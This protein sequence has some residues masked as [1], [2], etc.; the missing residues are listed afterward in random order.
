[1]H[2]VQFFFP[3]LRAIKSRLEGKRVLDLR[4]HI[5]E[6]GIV[7]EAVRRCVQDL[8]RRVE[9]RVNIVFDHRVLVQ[10]KCQPYLLSG[11]G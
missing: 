11:V 7:D 9:H 5:L 2:F 3:S 6:V 4:D 10:K 1:M 8:L